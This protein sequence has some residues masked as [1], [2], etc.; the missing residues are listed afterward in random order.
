MKREYIN[1]LIKKS[2]WLS[3][4]S[5]TILLADLFGNFRNKFIEIYKLDPAYILSVAGLTWQACLMK[6]VI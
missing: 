2:M 3:W 5:D 4:L 6:T 1:N